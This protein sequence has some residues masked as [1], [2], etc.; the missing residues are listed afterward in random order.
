A[1]LTIGLLAMLAIP[2]FSQDAKTTIAPGEKA[3]QVVQ[4]GLKAVGGE[5][6]AQ[7]KTVI[8]R[9]LFTEVTDGVSSITMKFVDYISYTDKERTEF[10]GG[11]AR[12]VQTNYREGC[13][14]VD[15][16]G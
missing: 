1:T 14:I 10:A 9:G 3:E 13:W 15:G 12:T 5:S 7:V 16:A 2:A 8:G 11:G 6:Y 4:R